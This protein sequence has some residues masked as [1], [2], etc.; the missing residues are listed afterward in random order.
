MRGGGDAPFAFKA[1]SL[2]PAAQHSFFLPASH[3]LPVAL[4]RT[5]AIAHKGSSRRGGFVHPTNFT[6]AEA[7]IL[8]ENVILVTSA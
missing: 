8:W 6:E 4:P 2:L 7:R 5:T 1:A 3:F